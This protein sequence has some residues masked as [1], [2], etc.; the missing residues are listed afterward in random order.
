MV[1]NNLLYR[2][3]IEGNDGLIIKFNSETPEKLISDRSLFGIEDAQLIEDIKKRPFMVIRNIHVLVQQDEK[4]YEFIVPRGYCYD[5]ATIPA[6]AW[7][8][9]G[10]KTEPRLKLASCIHDYLCEHHV[11][12]NSDRELSTNIFITLCEFFGKFN[13]VKRCIMKAT[14]NFF[15]KIFCGW[16]N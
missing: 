2:L 4:E 6:I 13:K 7:I 12:I 14:I 11:V 10:Q 15:Q 1:R 5:G 8:F 9:I 3:T 16:G